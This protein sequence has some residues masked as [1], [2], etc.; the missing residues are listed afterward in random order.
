MANSNFQRT[1]GR[2]KFAYLGID[3][4]NP[5]DLMPAG[6]TPLLLNVSSDKSQGALV[7]RSG[8]ARLAAVGVGDTPHSIKRLNDNVPGAS[9]AWQY[10]VGAGTKLYYGRGP[11]NQLDTGYS[12]NP[13]SMVPYRP[14][15]SPESWLYVFD[16]AKQSK[17][18]TDG[19]KQKVGVT[20]PTKAP[21]SALASPPIYGGFLDVSTASGW[22]N[23]GIAG[24]VTMVARIPTDTTIFAILYDS[25]ITGWCMIQPLNGADDYSGIVAGARVQLSGVEIVTV[26]QAFARLT[27]TTVSAISYDNGTSGLCTLVPSISLPGLQRNMLIRVN[28]N[29]SR[30]LSVTAGPDGQYSVRCSLPTGVAAGQVFEIPPS[31]RCYTVNQTF[32]TGTIRT[33]ALSS[34]LTLPVG[35][36]EGTGLIWALIPTVDATQTSGRPLSLEDYMH[37]SL[38]VDNPANVSE[39]HLL[40]DVDST[41]HDFTHNYFYYVLRQSDFQQVASGKGSSL[42]AQLN[43]LQNSIANTYT[44]IES[45]Q[46]AQLG[47]PAATPGSFGSQNSQQLSTGNSQWYEALFK[48]NELTRVGTDESVG[49]N[50]IRALGVYVVATG[51]V[52]VQFGSWWAGGSYGPDSNWNSYG[53]QGQPILYRYRYR[54]STSGA[55]SD[56]SPATR[57]GEIP[58]RQAVSINVTASSDT[59]VDL[60]DIERNGG[61]FDTWHRVLTVPNVT[62]NY[63]DTTSESVALASDPLELLTYAPW[64]ITDKPRRG[65]CNIVGTRVN[66]A[67]GDQFNTSWI[68]GVEFIVNNQTYTLHAPP[69]SAT[70][71][72]LQ[73]NVGVLSNVG[74][75]IPEAT[76]IGY[77]L[78]CVCLG[79][80]GRLFAT[81]DP[82]NPGFLYFGNSYNPDGCSDQ[83]Y[84]EITSPSDPLGPPVFYDGAIYVHSRSNLYRVD[85]TPGQVNPYAA[86]KLGGVVGIGANW[87]ISSEGPMLVW[88]GNDL[89]I[90]A[91]AAGNQAANLVTDD[92]YPLFPFESRPGLAVS[93]NGY[94]LSPPDFTQTAAL[95]LG[96]A[97]GRLYFDYIDTGGSART[98]VFNP[99]TKGW[100][101]YQYVPG[102]LLHYQEEGV[103]NPL[104]LALCV[105]GSICTLSANTDDI[106]VP[107][108]CTVMTPADDQGETRAKKQ[109]G[110]LLLD[111][112]G[113]PQTSVYYD[114]FFVGGGV[115]TTP[116]LVQR[117]QSVLDLGTDALHRNISLALSWLSNTGTALYEWQPSFIAMPED[118]VDRP[119]DW[120]DAGTLHYKFVHGLRIYADT[121]G[122]PRTVQIQYDGGILGPVLAVN[123]AGQVVL[124]Y[125]FPPFKAHIMRLVPTDSSSW[126]LFAVEWEV[127]LEPEAT[128]YWVTQPTSFGLS[129]YL[130]MR[131][132]YLA[133]ASLADGGVLTAIV[134]G[135]PYT[136]APNLPSTHGA[137]IKRYF[138]ALPLKG[139]LWQFSGAGTA[140]QIYQRDCEFRVKPWGGGS[141]TILKPIGDTTVTSEGAKI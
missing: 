122:L 141:Y 70:S 57:D 114:N 91:L 72:Q 105:G 77:P 73:E 130:H 62:G 11:L 132:F 82:Y 45:Q 26:Q 74:F 123:H 51:N 13:M 126:R 64:P 60:I 58:R 25:G 71:L 95:R 107:F 38:R 115:P 79:L 46:T 16:S 12:G 59:Q 85:S 43:A 108:T 127:D 40:F 10:F 140:L 15:Q 63:N 117:G 19:T 81:G 125:S 54:S 3:L 55:Y 136:I 65:T 23:N 129:G 39:I 66:W 47:Y 133:Y 24:A 35:T 5:P 102:V 75:I 103:S 9:Q 84:I 29:N 17:Y 67:S 52:M 88:L 100:I 120:Q 109:Y 98:L 96:F 44:D 86:Y 92:L 2:G 112:S 124:P 34:S 80:D 69:E 7:P 93:T 135:V 89:N 78:P 83:G 53:N 6:R 106:G 27:T 61:T 4:K 90:Y 22:V 137:E 118:A 139:K 121:G 31:F 97:N 42:Q 32:A 14:P 76:I 1:S 113:T 87:A 104:T 68:R 116:A 101:S 36:T 50:T 18:K 49:L 119:T 131:D 20:P 30:V 94:L 8:L 128:G 33:N 99:E 56:V 111:Y 37:M 48:I 134:D 28:G 41:T 138:P 110:D 21:T